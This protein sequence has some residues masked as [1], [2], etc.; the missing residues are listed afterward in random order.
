M[1][2][3]GTDSQSREISK[4]LLDYEEASQNPSEEAVPPASRVC[5]KLGHPLG[6]LIGKQ[7]YRAILVRGLTLAQREAEGLH[8]VKVGDD[9]NLNG[10]DGATE[11]VSAVLVAHVIALILTFLGE[12]TV[13]DHSSVW[14]T[15]TSV[16]ELCGEQPGC[17]R[18]WRQDHTA[19]LAISE[20]RRGSFPYTHFSR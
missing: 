9:G 19:V 6:K 18:S 3:N 1:E 11:R 15:S 4:Q 12:P 5:Q 8:A 16:L 20:S 10:L 14:R 2:E 17:D 7:G 13:T